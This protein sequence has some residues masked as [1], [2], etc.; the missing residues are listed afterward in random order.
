MV[1]YTFIAVDL[2]HLLLAGLPAHSH[3]IL[4]WGQYEGKLLTKPSMKSVKALLD[5]VR[6]IVRSNVSATQAAL[7]QALN[8][9][10]EGGS[11]ITAMR[12]RKRASP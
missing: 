2:H 6:E 5:K 9:S 11:C 3:I 10:S 4:A 7:N 12:L 1:R 8:R